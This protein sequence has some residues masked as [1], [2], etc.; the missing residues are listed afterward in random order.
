MDVLNVADDQDALSAFFG[1]ID[2]ER[3]SEQL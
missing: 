1:M 3:S 2:A